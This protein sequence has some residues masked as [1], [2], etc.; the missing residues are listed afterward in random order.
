MGQDESTPQAADDLGPVVWE[1]KASVAVVAAMVI[2]PGLVLL[3][4]GIYCLVVGEGWSFGGMFAGIW[5]YSC[6]CM[7]FLLL[8]G[9]VAHI[10]LRGGTVFFHERGL[11]RVHF[12]Q[13]RV[14]RY[15]DI[16]MMEFTSAAAGPPGETG[17]RMEL[18]L[19]LATGRPISVSYVPEAGYEEQTR[20][21]RTLRDLVAAFICERMEADLASRRPVF[22]SARMMVHA[23]GPEFIDDARNE[24]RVPWADVVADELPDL[25]DALRPA[26]ERPRPDSVEVRIRGQAEAREVLYSEEPNFDPMLLL[27]RAQIARAAPAAAAG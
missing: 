23:D 8:A 27:L 15:R 7:S 13:T 22:W 24:T 25:A 17:D 6:L 10:R 20:T 18:T 26:G 19:H 4:V 11:R 21:F 1:R 9:G 12:G 5:G 3:V 14:E 2:V 16:R